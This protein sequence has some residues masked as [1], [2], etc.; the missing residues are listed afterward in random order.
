[1]TAEQ[2]EFMKQAARNLL[3]HRDAGNRIDREA[4]RWAI[5]LLKQNPDRQAALAKPSK[6]AA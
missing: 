2:F 4:A 1:M 5:Q 3:A 6:A